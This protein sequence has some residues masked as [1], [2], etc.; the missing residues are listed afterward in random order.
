M[1]NNDSLYEYSIAVGAE[2]LHEIFQG[3]FQAS[4]SLITIHETWCNNTS[5]LPNPIST[6]YFATHLLGQQSIVSACG[7]RFCLWIIRPSAIRP[8]W[9]GTIYALSNCCGRNLIWY[10]R[11][12]TECAR[13]RG[14]HRQLTDRGSKSTATC[15]STKITARWPFKWVVFRNSHDTGQK[16]FSDVSLTDEKTRASLACKINQAVFRGED[17]YVDA[18]T[19]K[20]HYTDRT[21]ANW[22]VLALRI[23]KT[24]G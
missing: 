1:Y 12:F 20:E 2:G 8:K 17:Q 13:D 18:I 23:Y 19:N 14:I 15:W 7:N 11:R 6:E 9:V 22:Y 10:R 16:V 21:Q 4:C 5:K 24:I 3:L